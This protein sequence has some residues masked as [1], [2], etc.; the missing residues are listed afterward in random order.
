MLEGD[1][2]DEFEA[3][4]TRA[5][6]KLASDALAYGL[7]ADFA[8]HWAYAMER[9]HARKG[10]DY[11]REWWRLIGTKL[12]HAQKAVDEQVCWEIE[13]AEGLDDPGDDQLDWGL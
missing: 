10:N 3:A 6:G 9:H 4:A 13:E 5:A 8:I 7:D 2:W 12:I 1:Q 11:T